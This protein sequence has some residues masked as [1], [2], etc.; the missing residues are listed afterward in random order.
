LNKGPIALDERGFEPWL[1]SAGEPGEVVVAGA[2]VCRGYFKDEDAFTRTKIVEADGTVWHRTGDVGY[3]D[4]AANLHLVGRVHNT[5]VRAGE[6]L[7][8]V[9]PRS[10]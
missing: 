4:E 1:V 8:P 7:Y 9:T 5:I 6:L 3:L 2:H 10:C